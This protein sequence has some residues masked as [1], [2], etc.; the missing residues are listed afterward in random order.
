MSIENP[1][2]LVKAVPC[3]AGALT[4]TANGKSIDA[5]GAASVAFIYQFG[6]TTTGTS[7]T[8][9]FTLEES[10][11]DSSFT[12]ITG[13]ATS[14]L[15]TD[16]GGQNAKRVCIPISMIGR[17][18]YIRG[19]LTVAGTV[20]VAA[21]GPQNAGGVMLAGNLAQSLKSSDFDTYVTLV[22]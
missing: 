11:D 12:A 17:K 18:R 3:L 5:L 14:A 7:G 15:T 9:T 2:F 8:V 13:A 1:A 19:V 21:S 6:T 4:A 10:S 20:A 16:S 22:V